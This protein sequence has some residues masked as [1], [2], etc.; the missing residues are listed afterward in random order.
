MSLDIAD[1]MVVMGM[2]A[3]SM[4]ARAGR[5]SHKNIPHCALP[6][7]RSKSEESKKPYQES[8]FPHRLH[9]L[10]LDVVVSPLVD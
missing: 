1:R 9:G 4:T 2:S 7:P 8:P 5:E 3:N 10:A 6:W